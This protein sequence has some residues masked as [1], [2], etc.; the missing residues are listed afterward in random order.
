MSTQNLDRLLKPASIALL[1]AST[2]ADSP[3]R[4][5]ARNLF[6]GGFSGPIL[7]VTP[8]YQSVEGALAYARIEDLPIVPDLAVI[9]TPPDTVPAIIEALG[10]RGTKAAIVVASGFGRT[11]EQEVAARYRAVLMAARPHRLRI[12]GPDSLGLIVPALGL[13]ASVGPLAPKRGDIAFIAQSGSIITSVIDWAAPRGIGFSHLVALGGM[14]DVD[15]GDL[16]DY[17]AA[18][19]GTRAILLYLETLTSPRKFMSAARS[20]ARSKPVIVV[21]SGHRPETARSIAAH[22]GTPVGSDAVYDAAIRRAGM[23]RAFDLAELFD[24]VATLASTGPQRGDR[25]AI[26]TNGGGPGMLA[27]DALIERGGRLAELSAE[28]QAALAGSLAVGS[29][30]ENPVDIRFDAGPERYGRALAALTTDRGVDAVL[31]LHSP[32][33]TASAEDTA[34]TVIEA[35]KPRQPGNGI[36]FGDHRLSGYGRKN[37]LTNWLGEQQAAPARRLFAEHRIATYDTP[38]RAVRGFMHMVRYRRNQDLL[39]ETPPSV[40][41]TVRPRKDEASTI[42]AGIL[43]DGRKRPNEAEARRL[44]DCY[45][46]PCIPSRKAADPAQAAAIAREMA[47]EKAVPVALKIES[48]DIVHKSDLGGVVLNLGSP[49][50]VRHVAEEMRERVAAARPD[51]RITGFQVQE[52]VIR[53]GAIELIVGL[54]EDPLFGPVVLFGHGGTAA[55]ILDDQS[56]ELPPLNLALARAQMMRTRV[57]SLLQGYRSQPAAAVQDVAETLVK[58]A[59]MAIDLPELVALEINPLIA[60]QAG[61][62]ALDCRIDLRP[63]TGP[64]TARLAIRPYPSELE[65][66][67]LLPDGT[68][69]M[70][71][72]IRPEDEPALQ[73]AFEHMA[74]EDVRLRY[75]MPLKELGHGLAAR[76]TQ[77]DYDRE[78]ALVAMAGDDLLGDVR[79]IADPDNVSAEYAIA[80][81]SGVKG[82]G[83]GYLLMTRILAIAERRG[84]K[85]VRGDVLRENDAML[86]IC[87]D[88][89]FMLTPNAEDPSLM[90]VVKRLG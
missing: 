51:A 63:S 29:R 53:P 32:T 24:A 28:T 19:P 68:K 10:A 9:A 4:V 41:E 6:R 43:A 13:N 40:S 62:L 87:R 79:I 35:L 25:L 38:D 3:G 64:G 73:L 77:I 22:A 15:F 85:E 75:F 20:A 72:P 80:L 54:R 90:N 86:G 36:S 67:A 18:D 17:L 81:R 71:R 12:L 1:G 52:M 30:I 46:I 83:L 89:G 88:L 69:V 27:V 39:M 76:L 65:E 78:M 57:W 37:V 74:P 60:D 66:E 59:Q 34:Q 16:L 49:E 23:L 70:L 11:L 56:L 44:L 33:P 2:R 82:K 84:L 8:K 14:A 21:K 55:D 5:I 61:V 47:G 42:I 58:V 26:L 50:R 45:G 31:V 48:P 7:P